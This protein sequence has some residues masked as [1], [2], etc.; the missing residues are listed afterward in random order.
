MC[1]DDYRTPR[2]CY[3]SL[4]RV[5]SRDSSVYRGLSAGP[6]VF[7]PFGSHDPSLSLF[8]R[9]TRR[10]IGFAGDIAFR[11]SPLTRSSLPFCRSG[12]PERHC[13]QV[14]PGG[15]VLPLSG[16]TSRTRSFLRF[17]ASPLRP[18]FFRFTGGG[19][20]PPGRYPFPLARALAGVHAGA[21]ALF[22]VHWVAVILP[23][24][25]SVKP[26]LPVSGCSFS[27][28]VHSPH[29]LSI[30]EPPGCCFGGS[31]PHP[32]MRSPCARLPLTAFHR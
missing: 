32:L 19:R 27:K 9:T 31:I 7:L 3:A 18:C 2:G 15:L 1:Q 26:V 23:Q 30:H 21:I 20:I 8:P 14:S 4:F 28:A 16:I 17:R 11:R 22:P 10:R 6:R 13:F 24:G 12:L 5:R 25:F 29:S